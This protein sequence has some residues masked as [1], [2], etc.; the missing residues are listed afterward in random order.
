MRRGLLH[1]WQVISLD[2]DGEYVS[3]TFAR[4]VLTLTTLLFVPAVIAGLAFGGVMQAVGM[5]LI[6][7]ASGIAILIPGLA[8]T[9]IADTGVAVSHAVHTTVKRREARA[10]PEAGTVSVVDD[11]ASAG[12]LSEP[13]E[14]GT[15][16][17]LPS[18][19]E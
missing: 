16:S 8:L 3:G 1:A 9:A 7:L 12:C 17:A 11:D 2:W 13:R 10:N 14:P 19:L 18:G 4:W 5:G 6:V 15:L